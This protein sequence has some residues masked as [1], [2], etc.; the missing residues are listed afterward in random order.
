MRITPYVS[1]NT[2]R[3]ISSRSKVDEREKGHFVLELS[4]VVLELIAGMLALRIEGE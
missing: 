4:N 1:R 3:G 2:P